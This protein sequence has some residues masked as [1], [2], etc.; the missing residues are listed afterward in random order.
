MFELVSA[1]GSVGLSLGLPTVRFSGPCFILLLLT[2]A[3]ANYSFSGAFSTISK[4]IVCA[5]MIRGRHRGLP[6]AIDRAVMYPREYENQDYGE[7]EETDSDSENEDDKSQTH[8][9]RPRVLSIITEPVP[10]LERHLHRRSFHRKS[11]QS[12]GKTE[13]KTDQ[14]P[15]PPQL[16]LSQLSGRLENI[17]D[18]SEV[19]VHAWRQDMEKAKTRASTETLPGEQSSNASYHRSDTSSSHREVE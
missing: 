10:A 14:P 8:T 19:S 18:K 17:Q 4:L 2:C 6:V 12:L 5:V 13:S 9:H 1:Y 7:G 16:D 15:N 3:Q 11:Q